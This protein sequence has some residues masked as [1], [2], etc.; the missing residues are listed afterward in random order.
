MLF[1]GSAAVYLGI[2]VALFFIVAVSQKKGVLVSASSGLAGAAGFDWTSLRE[3]PLALLAWPLWTPLSL[4]TSVGPRS[5]S[6]ANR[7]VARARAVL[8]EAARAASD[9]PF[10]T[11]LPVDVARR[12]AQDLDRVGGRAEELDLVLSRPEFD[13]HT[14]EQ[15]VARLE[16]LG[17]DSRA[18]ATARIHVD[19]IRRLDSL[20]DETRRAVVSI[21][22][23]CAALRDQLVL[24]RYAGSHVEGIET[25]FTELC[26]RV[27][28]LTALGETDMPSSSRA[29][30]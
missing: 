9:S 3:L 2:G 7:A 16:S 30:A 13:L 28:A 27:D 19:T 12:V 11:L 17:E 26:A 5:P 29:K 22:D 15:R 24:A 20:R 6:R 8:E 14:A 18:L 21:E 23:L 25:T 1:L 10:S 4:A